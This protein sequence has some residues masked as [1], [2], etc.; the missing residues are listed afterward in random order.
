MIKVPTRG[1]A[2]GQKRY[3]SR[4][5]RHEWTLVEVKFPPSPQNTARLKPNY[6]EKTFDPLRCVDPHV[7][8][9]KLVKKKQNIAV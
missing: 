6:L 1:S 5:Y 4:Q 2:I 7:P 9:L 3:E 8:T